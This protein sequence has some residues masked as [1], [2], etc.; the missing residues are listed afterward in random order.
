[1]LRIYE[2]VFKRVHED[3]Q[4]HRGFMKEYIYKGSR[5]SSTLIRVYGAV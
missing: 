1:M 2:K 3:H 5:G 4:S